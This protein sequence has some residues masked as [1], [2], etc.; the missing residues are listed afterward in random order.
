MYKCHHRSVYVTDTG[1]EI[2]AVA[3]KVKASAAK[4]SAAKAG[5][6]KAVGM[7]DDGR[8]CWEQHNV[9]AP[10]G[11]GAPCMAS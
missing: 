7:R 3:V 8:C 4:A 9:G 2:K 1:T 11:A 5:A 6:A 10:Q